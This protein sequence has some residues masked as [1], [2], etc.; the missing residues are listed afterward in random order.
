MILGNDCTSGE[1][2]YTSGL[3]RT[4]NVACSTTWKEYTRAITPAHSSTEYYRLKGK[5]ENNPLNGSCHEQ[6]LVTLLV[7]LGAFLS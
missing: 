3:F 7:F 6:K 2:V 4:G 5:S 1:T